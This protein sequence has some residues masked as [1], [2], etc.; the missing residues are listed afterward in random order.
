MNKH[1]IKI[2]ND[3]IDNKLPYIDEL[4]KITSIIYRDIN[5]WRYYLNYNIKYHK[6]VSSSVYGVGF[7]FNYRYR[8]RNYKQYWYIT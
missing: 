8:I 2:V 4:E 3:Y 7:R 1:L 5:D 6:S